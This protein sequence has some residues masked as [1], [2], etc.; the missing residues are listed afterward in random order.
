MYI[1]VNL[2][3]GLGG[4]ALTYFVYIYRTFYFDCVRWNNNCNWF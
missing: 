1:C 3:P 2:L 4:R